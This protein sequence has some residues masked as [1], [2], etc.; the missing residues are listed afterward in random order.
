MHAAGL[1]RLGRP[2]LALGLFAASSCR[3][4][5]AARA[6]KPPAV[7]KPA[8]TKPPFMPQ[9]VD[10]NEPAMGTEVHFVAYTTPELDEVKIGAAM[11]AAHAEIV[12]VEALMTSWKDTGEIARINASPG[13]PVVVSDETVSVLKKSRWA[14]EISGG[15]FDIT[16]HALSDLWKF[17]DAAEDPPRLPTAKDVA[18]KKKFV[19]Y[20]KIVIDETAHTVTLPRGM[21][22]DLGGIAK[23]YAVDHAAAV[24]KAAGLTSFLAQAGGDLFGAGRKPDGSPWV[25]GIQDPRAAQGT[26]F[27]TIELT[28]HAFSTAGDYARSFFVGGKRYHHIIDPRTGYPATACRS[29][30]VWAGDAFTADAVDDAVFILGP[31]KGLALVESLPDVGAVIVDAKNKVWLSARLAGKVH[32]LHPPMDGP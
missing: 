26:F 32:V 23:G 21:S 16:F 6:E 9:R 24:L 12:R 11:H 13:K 20:R 15:V 28:D 22:M 8:P 4:E 30:T 19:D 29:V 7:T 3:G 18:A 1:G 2:L 17:G 10:V 14:G 5:E 25:S 31:E 27:A